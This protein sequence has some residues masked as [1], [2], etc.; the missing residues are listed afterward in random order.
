MSELKNITIND[1]YKVKHFIE[2]T[3]F[4]DVYTAQENGSDKFVS[5]SIYKNKEIA[6]YDL[7]TNGDLRE[8]GF[9]KLGID[10]FPMLMGFGDF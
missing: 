9:L 3:S 4:C 1:K 2:S 6:K 7:D 8:I 10:G 5:I